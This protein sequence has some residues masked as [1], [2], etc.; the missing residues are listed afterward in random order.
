MDKM[1]A[2]YVSVS[3]S[4]VTRHRMWRV[5]HRG[6]PVC[7]DKASMGEALAV[8]EEF[9]STRE[10]TIPLWDGDRAEWD[11]IESQ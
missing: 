3:M 5:I 9:T 8:Y 7:A 1:P 10:N 11:T 6:M 4:T 2:T